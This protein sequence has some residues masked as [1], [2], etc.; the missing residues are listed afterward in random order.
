MIR[1]NRSDLARICLY[2]EAVSCLQE[3]GTGS[4]GGTVLWGWGSGDK[5][6]K[7]SDEKKVQTEVCNIDLL[8]ESLR[9]WLLS[10]C[11]SRKR[12]ARGFIFSWFGLKEWKQELSCQ[13]RQIGWKRQIKL[14]KEKLLIRVQRSDELEMSSE[15]ICLVT[16]LPT[17][18]KMNVCKR[19]YWKSSDYFY[20]VLCMLITFL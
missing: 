7:T 20:N 11:N 5:I 3:Y 18:K 12:K 14:A 13:E 10:A 4:A 17:F 6:W 8:E 1:F 9:Q 19:R 15:R 16:S 2:Y